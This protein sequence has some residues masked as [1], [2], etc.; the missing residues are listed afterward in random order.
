MLEGFLCCQNAAHASNARRENYSLVPESA[1]GGRRVSCECRGEGHET[2][3]RD[4]L[5][6]DVYVCYRQDWK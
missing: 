1:W 3:A 6:M 4:A 2:R 5:G